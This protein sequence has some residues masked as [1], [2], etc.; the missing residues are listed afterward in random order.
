MCVSGATGKWGDAT[1]D[2]NVN[3]VDAQQVARFSVGL[4]V[5][6]LAALQNSGDVT[7]D[8]LVNIVDA[9]QIARFSV[10]LSAAARVN[11]TFFNAP[12]VASITGT[13]ANAALQIGQTSQAT[14]TPKD[15]T[16]ASIL[17]CVAVAWS[18]LTPAIATVDSTGFITAVANGAVTIRATAGGLN[19]DIPVQVGTAAAATVTVALGSSSLTGNN[20]TTATATVRDQFNNVIAGAPVTWSS[21]TPLVARITGGGAVQA[22]GAGTSAIRATSGAV[23]GSSTLTVTAAPGQ[24][25]IDVR[26]V[27]SMTPSQLAAFTNGANRWMQIIRG[28]VPNVTLN[29]NLTACGFPGITVNETVD[30]LIIYASIA[31]IDGPGSILAQAGPCIYRSGT[32]FTIIGVMTFD[33]ADVPSMEANGTFQAVVLHEMGHIMGVGTFWSNLGLLTDGGLADPIF[34]GTNAL[35]AF[36]NIGFGSYAGRPVPVE[37]TG[38]SGTRDAHW[39]ESV[40]DRELMTGYVEPGGVPMPLT[41]LT[42]GSLLDEGHVVDFSQADPSSQLFSALARQ[43]VTLPKIPIVEGVMPAPIAVDATGRPVPAQPSRLRRP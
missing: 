43:G 29:Q 38:G 19:F 24:F 31:A 1:G 5:T 41:A 11:T 21:L 30:D 42:I 35:W 16:N 14:A 23:S 3:I 40:L 10:G 28:D 39:R 12:T 7:A 26:V 2:N 22:L 8:G 9:Q 20:T 18:S 33:I 36:P 25:N 13:P 32:A 6:N 17:G 34:T 27:G 4:S 37:N 15:G